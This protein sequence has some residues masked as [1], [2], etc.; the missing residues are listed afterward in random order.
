MSINKRNSPIC[1]EHK[2]KKEWRKTVFEYEESGIMVK[3]PNIYAWVCP[4]DNEASFTPETVDELIPTIRELL[5]TAKRAK[6]RRSL[7]TEFVVTI[8]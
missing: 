3:I 6:L 8:N 4:K 7:S 2:N 1:S 5:E